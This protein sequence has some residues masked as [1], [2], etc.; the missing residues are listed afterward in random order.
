VAAWLAGV[1]C[2]LSAG[3][4]APSS[5][6]AGAD[7]TTTAI[8]RPAPAVAAIPPRAIVAAGVTAANPLAV[9]AG[10]EV[11]RAGGSAADAAVAI[12]AM[13]GL[14]EPQSSGVGGGAFLLHYD[15][16]TRKVTAYDGRETAP[17]AARPSLFLDAAGKP[18]PFADAVTSGRSTG[19]PGVMPM[20]GALHE[21]H[22]QRDWATLFEPAIR[23]AH[24]GFS[25]PRRLGRFVKATFP[26]A[27]LDPARL[28][29]R[30]DGAPLEAGDLFR[31]EAYA[32]TL[33]R[34][35]R[36]GPRALLQPPLADQ[37]VARLARDPLPGSMT[38]ADL[39][40]YRPVVE[41]AVCGPYRV[42]RV[43]VPPPPS[44]GISLLQMLA[45]LDRT[46]IADRTPDDPQAWYLFAEASRLMYADRDRYIADPAYVDVPVAALLDPGYVA[47]RAT[48]I[49]PR[50]GPAPN[51]GELES[52]PRAADRT[53]EASG[54]SHFVAIDAQGNVASMTTS[55]ES[56]FGSGRAVGGFMLNNQLTDFSFDPVD[57]GRPAANAVAGGKRPRSSMSP[58]MVLDRDGRLVAALGSPGGSAILAYNAKALVALLAWRLP[59]Q[60]AID[61]PNLFARGDVYYGEVAKFTPSTLAGLAA[62]G[63]E[64]KPGRGEESGLHAVVRQPDGTFDGAA[65]PR[66]EG[67]WRTVGDESGRTGAAG[68]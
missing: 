1:A 49:G 17:Q 13:L 68:P 36:L 29:V 53:R 40:A 9:E 28:F 57:A 55:V 25:V 50:A 33:R 6:P 35:A 5:T 26:Q 14:V 46:D 15:A 51:A 32:D 7:A 43:C 56:V 61:L 4:Q 23:A 20:L 31:N 41:E 64:I 21:R 16:A 22:G 58:V 52:L 3:C 47:S 48:L 34:L 62:L 24:D 30:A 59:V 2:L 44:S 19:V 67:V 27:R 18:M 37:I 63:I 42:Y 11:L 54:T 65:D 8:S 10:L 38:A 60:R 39:A 12:Q 45:I 66:R